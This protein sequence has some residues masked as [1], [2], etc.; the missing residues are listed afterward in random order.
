MD[1]SKIGEPP[2]KQPVVLL[3]SVVRPVSSFPPVLNPTDFMNFIDFIDFLS[4]NPIPAR[5]TD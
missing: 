1:Q 4:L 2:V 3:P 5:L